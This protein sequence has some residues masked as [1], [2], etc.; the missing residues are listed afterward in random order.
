MF[1]FI[2]IKEYIFYVL[3]DCSFAKTRKSKKMS[4]L[5]YR[6]KSREWDFWAMQEVKTLFHG[7]Q[8]VDLSF[9]H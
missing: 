8:S 3:C 5:S 9:T 2:D 1:K 7:L 4:F 6:G